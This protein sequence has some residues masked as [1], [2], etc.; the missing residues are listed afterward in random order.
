MKLIHITTCT[1]RKRAPAVESLLC[2]T[3][4]FGD[5]A[6]VA[7]EWT[8]RVLHAHHEHLAH[9]LYCG[10]GFSE[11]LSAARMAS[12]DLWVIS[13]GLGLVLSNEKIPSYSLTL[14]PGTDD[15]IKGRIKSDFHPSDWWNA[16]NSI[17]E[18]SIARLLNEDSDKSLFLIS[19]TQPYAPLILNDLLNLTPES[20]TRVRIVGLMCSKNMPKQIQDVCMPYDAR[21]N[22]PR[23]YPGTMSD[24]AQRTA[25][26]FVKNIWN[27]Y[28][29][30]SAEDDSAAIKKIM[31]RLEAPI[32]P[33]RR[34]LSDYEVRNEIVANWD[35]A[36]GYSNRM[37]RVLRDDLLVA[38]EQKRFSILFNQV[39]GEIK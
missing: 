15:S 9:S 8:T 30:Q 21:I 10:R 22:D 2:R 5:M 35:R 18:R 23:C 34:Q 1:N 3:L 16:I 33:S 32:I 36:Q 19:L 13:A 12:T 31:N 20:L 4:P 37:L 29:Y 28:G 27:E 38:C 11:S 25:Y 6:L 39:K 14:A 26:H 7:E 17:S 24:F